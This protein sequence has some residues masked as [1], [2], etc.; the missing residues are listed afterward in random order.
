MAEYIGQELTE[1]EVN[2]NLAEVK[3]TLGIEGFILNDEELNVLR[4]FLSG[5]I[6]KEQ[7]FNLFE[8]PVGKE[9]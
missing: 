1:E 3:A 9:Q 5:E 6:S 7:V 8:I 2:K 4:R